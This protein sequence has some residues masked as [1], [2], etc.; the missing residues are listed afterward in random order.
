MY[1]VLMILT[2][3]RVQLQTD[4]LI[5]STTTNFII[6]INTCYTYFGHYWPSSGI[7]YM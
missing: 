7:K 3:N 1:V 5:P 6:S 4:K 2:I